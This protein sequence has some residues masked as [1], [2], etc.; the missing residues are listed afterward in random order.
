MN[1]EET[2]GYIYILYIVSIC[3][4]SRYFILCKVFDVSKKGLKYE[5]CLRHTQ[6]FKENADW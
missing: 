4:A 3:Q 2:N 5:E 1:K 6:Y